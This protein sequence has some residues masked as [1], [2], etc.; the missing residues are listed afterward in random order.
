MPKKIKMESAKRLPYLVATQQ[1]GDPKKG[2]RELIQNALDSHDA[3]KK[4][5]Q[6]PEPINIGLGRED[7]KSVLYFSDNGVG[8]GNTVDEFVKKM[9]L[10]GAKWKD[11]DDRGDF[12]IG[13]GQA[14]GMIYDPDIDNYDGT[15]EVTTFIQGT[16]YTIT[17]FEVVGKEGEQEIVFDY[18]VQG[19]EKKFGEKNLGTE[20][21]IVSN[22][23]DFFDKELIEQYIIDNIRIEEPILLNRRVISPPFEG[24]KRIITLRDEKTMKPIEA[25]VYFQKGKDEFSIYNRGLKVDITDE[26][27]KGWGGDIITKF[28]LKTGV[29]REKIHEEDDNYN[30]IREDLTEMIIDKAETLVRFNDSQKKGLQQ[31]IYDSPAV[32]NRL[33]DKKIFIQTDGSLAS[34]SDIAR[35]QKIFGGSWIG[36]DTKFNADRIDEGRVILHKD[37]NIWDWRVDKLLRNAGLEETT[38]VEQEPQFEKILVQG[39]KEFEPTEKQRLASKLLEKII[40]DSGIRPR[41]VLWG[42]GSARAWTN[43]KDKIWFHIDKWDVKDIDKGGS[44]QARL[45][46]SMIPTLIDEVTHDEDTRGTMKSHLTQEW[47]TNFQKNTFKI[48]EGAKKLFPDEKFYTPLTDSYENLIHEIERVKARKGKEKFREE[49]YD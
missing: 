31:L 47:L 35:S 24:E 27:V 3:R 46:F 45:I 22:K 5:G 13:R 19:G 15:I 26:I 4:L 8:W 48:T 39:F 1:A 30:N 17:G 44:Y 33:W 14:L 49:V 43:G 18:P 38:P 12:G 10:M 21:K 16:P 2:I 7:T 42:K 41:E 34:L 36:V 37:K 25:V 29:S 9:K 23:P 40:I 11:V 32:S 20:W 28:N 6:E